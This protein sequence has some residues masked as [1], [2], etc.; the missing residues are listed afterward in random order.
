MNHPLCE[1]F[2]EIC[3]ELPA[4]ALN[5]LL[6]VAQ[7]I[8]LARSTNLAKAKDYVSQVLG[9]SEDN[10]VQPRAH[11]Q[12]LIRFF[13]QAVTA[14]QDGGFYYSLQAAIHHVSLGVLGDVTKSRSRT[15]YFVSAN[16]C[17]MSIDLRCFAAFMSQQILKIVHWPRKLSCLCS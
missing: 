6:T 1:Q 2:K 3:S 4:H 14:E 12:R 16:S 13:D 8:C 7:C 11:Y 5:N 9:Y 17:D 15:L 10:E